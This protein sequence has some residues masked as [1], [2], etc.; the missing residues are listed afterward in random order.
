MRSG[1]SRRVVGDVLRD[2][3]LHRKIALGRDD[4][5][6]DAM[7]PGELD[8]TGVRLVADLEEQIVEAVQLGNELPCQ[9][10]L[11]SK[12]AAIVPHRVDV[13]TRNLADPVDVVR[14][15][16]R[17]ERPLQIL[18][19]RT[20][21]RQ[22]D[23]D[24]PG[25]GI[26][27]KVFQPRKV[28]IVPTGQIELVAAV[29]VTRLR[30][31][32]PRRDEAPGGRRQSISGDVESALRLDVGAA[33]HPRVVQAVGG[34]RV[35]IATIVEVEV[36]HRAVM[37]SRRDEDRR[38]A[39]PLKVVRIGWMQSQRARVPRRRRLLRTGGKRY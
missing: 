9:G 1:D 3:V 18:V 17:T 4:D 16:H 12:Q 24:V 5:V 21:Q 7:L 22:L 36:E 20:E 34:Q 6:G 11:N 13:G 14:C 31:A 2:Q 38:T 28:G 27:E 39:A 23:D 26:R 32:R 25:P 10:L 37:L 33:E 15:A 8:G 29:G 35:E 19:H 30:A